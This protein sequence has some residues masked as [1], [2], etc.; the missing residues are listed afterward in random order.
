M[1]QMATVLYLHMRRVIGLLCSLLLIQHKLLET[2]VAFVAIPSYQRTHRLPLKILTKRITNDSVYH[3]VHTPETLND[4]DSGPHQSN[5]D[6]RHQHP[7]DASSL[8]RRSLLNKIVHTSALTS[9][10]FLT[11]L[12][13]LA[14][15]PS[16]ASVL[17]T[18]I[19]SVGTLA[20]ISREEAEQRFRT[21][22]ESLQYLL[23]HYDKI[24]EGGG[25]N[26]RRYLGTVGVNG[27][28]GIGKALRVLGED[29]DDIVE[30]TELV[31]EIE[32]SIQQADGSAYMAI[33]TV[34]ST[35][36]VPSAKYFN[37]A[38]I[39]IERCAKSM[40]DLAAMIGLKP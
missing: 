33:F 7:L 5:S 38:K 40:D 21:G 11:S 3:I 12:I 13:S 1:A 18:S 27:L 2:T 14:P 34:T 10:A 30:Y 15:R 26:V 35:S 39:E 6:K 8:E 24:C 32:R 17:S 9:S 19:N 37:D 25:D 22:R 20:P 4:V 28:F 36:G 16:F 31:T 29:V 23:D